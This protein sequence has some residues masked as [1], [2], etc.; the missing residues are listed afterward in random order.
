MRSMHTPSVQVNSSEL[1][2][3]KRRFLNLNFSPKWLPGD[4]TN[5][6]QPERKGDGLILS[7]ARKIPA[8][9]PHV[10]SYLWSYTKTLMDQISALAAQSDKYFDHEDNPPITIVETSE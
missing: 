10:F 6:S 1:Q 4:E 9:S 3:L 8:Y 2:E 7:T 5:V